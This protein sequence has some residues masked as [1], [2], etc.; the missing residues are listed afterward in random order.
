MKF[1]GGVNPLTFWRSIL[2]ILTPFI[3]TGLVQ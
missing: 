3:L 1:P 2:A